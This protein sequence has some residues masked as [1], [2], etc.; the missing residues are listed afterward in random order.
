M[1]ALFTVATSAA[2]EFHERG[3]EKD[4]G[5]ESVLVWRL[6][7][8]THRQEQEHEHSMSNSM[9]KSL[10]RAWQEH[11]QER[12][13]SSVEV[14]VGEVGPV[15]IIARTLGVEVGGLG[16]QSTNRILSSV[17]AQTGNSC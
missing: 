7:P 12:R 3:G 11:E 15:S 4:L 16:D 5:Q 13:R 10:A 1:A 9:S 6:A 14:V 2:T 8:L 17:L